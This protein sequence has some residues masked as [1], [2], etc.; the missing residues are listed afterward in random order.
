MEQRPVVA[1]SG[2][3]GD[4]R[5][6]ERLQRGLDGVEVVALPLD[7]DSM[8]LGQEAL[9]RLVQ[10]GLAPNIV[11]ASGRGL[12]GYLLLDALADCAAA[13]AVCRRLCY[14][15]ESDSVFDA[16][17]TMRLPGTVN[18]KRETSG[19]VSTVVHFR[20]ESRYSLAE[21]TSRLDAA[22]APV[23]LPEKRD[24]PPPVAPRTTPCVVPV[25][26]VAPAV[27]RVV[28]HVPL[29]VPAQRVPP[30]ALPRPSRQND[31]RASRS[32]GRGSLA[33]SRASSS[34]AC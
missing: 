26:P 15:T 20:P 31:K 34:R 23:P 11:V 21:I 9:R 18:Q 14:W 5:R 7:Y 29:R 33:Q 10:C 3:P 6:G 4:P 13:R 22:G 8:A 32:S 2:K 16:P 24:R 28:P 19:A 1:R 27:P 30:R 12:H 25:V 17:R